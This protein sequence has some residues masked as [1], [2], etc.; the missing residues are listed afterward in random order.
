MQ[1][2]WPCGECRSSERKS[3]S[4]RKKLLLVRPSED[5]AHSGT[6]KTSKIAMMSSRLKSARVCFTLPEA[7]RKCRAEK[8]KAASGHYPGGLAFIPHAPFTRPV[9]LSDR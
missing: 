3:R 8:S 7:T 5:C 9:G 6:V 4:N 1:A 2:L